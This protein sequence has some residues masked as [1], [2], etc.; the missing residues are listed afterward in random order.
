MFSE[1]SFSNLELKVWQIES[2]CD[3][4]KP[5]E[6]N[7]YGQAYLAGPIQRLLLPHG[8]ENFESLWY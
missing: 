3:R 4:R 1:F 8:N 7:L 2:G 5:F 6:S